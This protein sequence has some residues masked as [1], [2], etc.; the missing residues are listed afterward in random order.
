MR[1]FDAMKM[2]G[3]GMMTPAL[4]AIPHQANARSVDPADQGVCVSPASPETART[5][6]TTL[7]ILSPAEKRVIAGNR[8]RL[9]ALRVAEKIGVN[10]AAC[11]RAPGPQPTH[12]VVPT[13]HIVTTSVH[14]KAAPSTAKPRVTTP[15]VNVKP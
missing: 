5:L 10:S 12:I 2:L 15:R 4:T 14:A 6:L 13:T 7:L 1:K 3:V 11:A 8:I 9:R